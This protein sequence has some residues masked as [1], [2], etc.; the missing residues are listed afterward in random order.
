MMPALAIT[1]KSESRNCA[2]SMLLVVFV[3]LALIA[4]TTAASAADCNTSD[5]AITA[6]PNEKV[7]PFGQGSILEEAFSQIREDFDAGHKTD[8]GI[9]LTPMTD[10]V[11]GTQD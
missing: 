3:T 6:G 11:E 1:K 4:P 7:V 5:G 10:Q 8:M 2:L 9:S